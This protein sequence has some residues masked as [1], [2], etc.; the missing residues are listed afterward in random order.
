MATKISFIVISFGLVLSSCLKP[1]EFPLEPIIEFDSFSVMQDS[2]VLTIS[3][4]D[5]DGD[6]G[7]RESDTTGDFAPDKLYHHNL[8]IDYYEKDDVLGWQRGKDLAGNDITFLYR[9][10]Y[11]TPNGNNTAL[12]GRIEVTL[13]PSYFNPLSDQSDTVKYRITLVDRNLTESNEV[14]SSVITR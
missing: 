10:P 2:A 7:L 14:E 6:I 5:G 11:L 3:F 13:E 1:Q 8:F 12:K 9:V 4:T